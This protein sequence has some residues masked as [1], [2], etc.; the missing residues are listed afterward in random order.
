MANVN[1]SMRENTAL[2]SDVVDDDTA[3]KEIDKSS[4]GDDSDKYLIEIW[5]TENNVEG[6]VIAHANRK[7]KHDNDNKHFYTLNEYETMVVYCKPSEYNPICLSY[8]AVRD[9]NCIIN[10]KKDELEENQKKDYK[11]T[12]ARHGMTV[13]AVFE[14]KK[15][16]DYKFNSVCLE[17]APLANSTIGDKIY[18]GVLLRD[19]KDDGVKNK[20][21][22]K[23]ISDLH[24]YED[25]WQQTGFLVNGA[26]LW[27]RKVDLDHKKIE[28][29]PGVE[30]KYHR[31]VD[32]LFYGSVDATEDAC[33]T[34]FLNG[35]VASHFGI[36]I[37]ADK[38]SNGTSFRYA[39]FPDNIHDYADNVAWKT[40]DANAMMERTTIGVL[41]EN[42]S[43]T[44]MILEITNAD[45]LTIKIIITISTLSEEILA[46][47]SKKRVKDENAAAIKKDL[48]CREMIE[49]LEDLKS[50]KDEILQTLHDHTAPI[51][52]ESVEFLMA[53]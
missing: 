48:S 49:L 34:R 22:T 32:S 36:S 3:A 26:T 23:Y 30:Q 17:K 5:S 37:D 12:T 16:G 41:L 45:N 10:S 14:Y 4:L 15:A 2:H 9:I 6:E 31:F 8:N 29:C 51:E 19:F 24:S 21:Y 47:I 28:S 39:T 35:Y 43:H 50:K 18:V 25:L 46:Q 38:R 53:F 20:N 7:E 33:G 1:G 40:S 52:E 42:N 44:K 13:A 11:R 27:I